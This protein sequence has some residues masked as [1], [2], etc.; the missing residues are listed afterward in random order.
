MHIIT[1]APLPIT[2]AS[3][4]FKVH[5]VPAANDNLIWLIEWGKGNAAVV[6]GPSAD[7]A[8]LYCQQHELTLRVIL[9][10]HTHGDHIG[11]NRALL[12][13]GALSSLQ[14]YGAAQ[15]SAEIP[16]LT[17]PLREGDLI[18]LGPLSISVWETE[19]HI[20]GHLSFILDEFLFCGDTLFAGGCGYL[21]D[22]PAEK[23]YRSLQRF[24]ALPPETYVCCAHE[25][26]EDNLRFAL[27]VEPTNQAIRERALHIAELRAEGKS[28]LP[29]TIALELS[30]NPFIRAASADDFAQKRSLKD[31]KVHQQE[32]A[33]PPK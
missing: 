33:W 17:H 15:R 14:V 19:G 8:L 27:L 32:I 26:T 4:L 29:S 21:F 6:D 5:Q 10:T 13:S 11:I 12:Q 2:S 20:N 31:R 30:T 9:N 3:R 16:G 18:K 24:A 22:G 23:M 25:Y 7:E 1:E 28:T